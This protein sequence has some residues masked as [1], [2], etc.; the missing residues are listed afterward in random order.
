MSRPPRRPA[1]A[2]DTKRNLLGVGWY[3]RR[4]R[5][6][7]ELANWFG[8]VLR[9]PLIR[10]RHP[11]H[12]FWA[13][14]T[15]V[16]EL[17]ADVPPRKDR[18]TDPDTAPMV[19][20]FATPDL[21]AVL[22]RLR[23]AGARVVGTGRFAG[24]RE[25]FVLDSDQQL[26]AL[27][28]ITGR[29]A[30]DVER[31]IEQYWSAGERFNPGCSAMPQDLHG[32]SWVLARVP[33]VAA[34]AAFYRDGV[35]LQPIDLGPRRTGFEIGPPWG[36]S[37]LLELRGGGARQPAVKTRTLVTNAFVLHVDNHRVMNRQLKERGA[38]I[39]N[40]HIQF[41]SAELTYA[42]SP[43]GQLIGFEERY[44]PHEFGVPR[45]EFLEDAE[46]ERRWRDWS[47][48]RARR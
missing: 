46:F 35:G 28:E 9:L 20:A 10:G 45:V 24:G 17:I 4:C 33:D 2:F 19:P 29:G 44:E 34:E 3:L 15:H 27:R 23:R 16:I 18:D 37:C 25:A 7:D 21:D 11:T 40:D 31:A 6:S 14:D 47:S 36:P 39:V 42:A 12:F 38:T 41:N 48:R 32:W 1:A 8:G 30:S 5:N 13:G 22:R 26:V 43:A